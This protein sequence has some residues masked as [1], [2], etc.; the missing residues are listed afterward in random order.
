ML[1][2]EEA[3]DKLI[4]EYI[5]RLPLDEIVSSFELKLYALKEEEAI[6]KGL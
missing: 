6:R 2:F 1:E 5:D 4:A 3:L